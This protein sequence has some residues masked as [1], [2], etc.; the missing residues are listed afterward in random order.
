MGTR[1][2]SSTP[3]SVA[4]TAHQYDVA[5]EGIGLWLARAIACRHGG[6]L[7][8]Q[9]NRG[10]TEFVLS[11]PSSLVYGPPSDDSAEEIDHLGEQS[12]ANAC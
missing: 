9:K 12:W 5:G 3:A 7:F 4:V 8:L 10:P 2:L 11:L 1:R 6:D